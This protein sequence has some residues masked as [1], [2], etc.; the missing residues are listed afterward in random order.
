MD[1][2]VKA[3]FQLLLKIIKQEKQSGRVSICVNK[4]ASLNGRSDPCAISNTAYC[5]V[6][7]STVLSSSFAP[8]ELLIAL[9]NP[10]LS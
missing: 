7:F 9:Q 2:V 10:F 4:K 3:H 5:W 8:Y 6:I 1:K